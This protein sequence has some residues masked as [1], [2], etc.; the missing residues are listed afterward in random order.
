MALHPANQ[1]RGSCT[2]GKYCDTCA[3]PGYDDHGWLQ[4][5]MG[6]AR[7]VGSAQ[8]WLYRTLHASFEKPGVV[9]G[10]PVLAVQAILQASESGLFWQSVK[11]TI[12]HRTRIFC[13][14]S[15]RKRAMDAVAFAGWRRERPRERAEM[16]VPVGSRPTV[17]FKR[18]LCKSQLRSSIQLRRIMRGL[19]L[20]IHP[21]YER[22]CDWLALDLRDRLLRRRALAALGRNVRAS[23]AA[24]ALR[25]RLR[26]W[27]IR[28]YEPGGRACR[29]AGD[30]FRGS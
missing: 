9:V 23:K 10:R 8:N 3:E 12:A 1:H 18:R 29:L 30:R 26:A 21:I 28:T 13:I 27:S 4:A 24:P 19:H 2:L 14:G 17:V 25:M 6:S 5:H 7:L 20:P 11:V 16:A 15:C 22:A